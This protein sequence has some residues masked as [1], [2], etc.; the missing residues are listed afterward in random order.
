MRVCGACGTPGTASPTVSGRMPDATQTVGKI[1][2][3][4]QTLQQ[5]N[6][7][8]LEIMK[9]EKRLASLFMC[10][11]YY[12]LCRES[13]SASNGGITGSTSMAKSPLNCVTKTKRVSSV[14]Y[15]IS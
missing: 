12:A 9:K 14:K 6:T 10:T 13:E 1:S 3:S 8:C 4:R 2:S 11:G 5:R 7:H 15:S